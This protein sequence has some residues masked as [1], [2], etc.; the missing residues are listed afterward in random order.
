MSTFAILSLVLLVVIIGVVAVV[1]RQLWHT[2]RHTME[3]QRTVGQR[4]QP[5]ADELKAELA[6]TSVEAEALRGG[7]QRLRQPRQGRH[8]SLSELRPGQGKRTS[9]WPRRR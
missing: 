2:L 9:R 6:V 5:L 4:L 1:A 3:V 7:I 8:R